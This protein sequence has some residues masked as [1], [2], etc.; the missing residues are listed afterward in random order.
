[1]RWVR[2]AGAKIAGSA[3]IRATSTRIARAE[4]FLILSVLKKG[5]R[6]GAR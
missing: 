4:N 6:D 5:Q 3:V 2:I 1:M